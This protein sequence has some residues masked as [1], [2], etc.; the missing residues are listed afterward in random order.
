MEARTIHRLLEYN[1]TGGFGRDAENPLDGDALIIDEC[2]MIDILLFYSLLKAVPQHM[3]VI[4]VG[5]IDQLPSVGAG[6]VLR[7]VIASGKVPVV[8]LTHIFRKP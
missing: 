8:R 5:D 7:D 6:N 3:R 2:S 4:M 1:P